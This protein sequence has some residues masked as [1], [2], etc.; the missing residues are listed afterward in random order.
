MKF[1]LKISRK[2]MTKNC[3]KIVTIGASSQKINLILY[4]G[5]RR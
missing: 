2:K 3:L 4:S 5:M 1:L